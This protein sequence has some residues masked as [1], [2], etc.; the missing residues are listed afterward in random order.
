MQYT[1]INEGWNA[2]PNSPDVELRV[3]NEGLM[4]EF[5]LNAFQFNEFK[6]GDKALVTFKGCHKFSFNAKNDESYHKGQY[7]YKHSELPWG[8]FYILDTDWETD[9]PQDH[10][11]LYTLNGTE[12]DLKHYI[13]F[14]KD[15]TFECVA[16][17]FTLELMRI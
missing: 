8:E 9:F 12:K 5:Y 15:N 11:V 1:K 14:F 4:L 6:E 16:Q 7:R 3:D 2:D 17:S 13:F 10:E